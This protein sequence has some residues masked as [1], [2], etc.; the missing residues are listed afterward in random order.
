RN[1]PLTPMT[2]SN[3]V[4][5]LGAQ[6]RGRVGLVDFSAVEAGAGAGRGRRGAPPRALAKGASKSTGAS[7]PKVDGA[8]AILAGSCS[9]ATLAQVEAAR[10]KYQSLR[11]APERLRR[12]RAARRG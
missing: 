10:A 7:L 1:H 9:E 12:R 2:D 5:A 3:L 11:L 4:R 8:A 6:T